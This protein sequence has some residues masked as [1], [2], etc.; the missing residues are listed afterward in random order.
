MDIAENALI[1]N[2]LGLISRA[3]YGCRL[4]T[5]ADVVAALEF[6]RTKGLPLRVLGAGSNVVPLPTVRGVVAVMSS[7]GIHIIEDASTE[8][9]LEIGAGENWH[10]LVMHCVDRGW[11]GIENLA[12]IPGSVGAAPVQN[13]GAYGVELCEV[14]D[15]VQIV[16]E[17][18]QLRWLSAKECEFGYR[19]S[20][21]Q[22]HSEL[23][24]VAVRL[25]LS[26]VA[27]PSLR[28]PDL[29]AYFADNSAV[30]A[31]Q[32][33]EAVI[34]IRS[35]KLPNPDEYPNV[36]SFFKNPVIDAATTD[37]F[38]NLGLSVYATDVGVKLSAAEL[39]DR[40]GWKEHPTEY[41]RCWPKQPLVLV[42]QNRANASHILSFA[43]D[44]RASVASTFGIQLELEPLVLS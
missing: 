41:V 8:L 2:T 9:L 31:R 24:I 3:E 28:Y 4:Q 16:D 43:N 30:T 10:Q 12:L 7:P 35:A 26:K 6:A 19:K 34:S 37:E 27:K 17:Q 29:A 20:L 1:P 40:C 33:A 42:C 11:S 36:G 18:Q 32:V 22:K 23:I 5:P 25:R 14:L 15:S 39:I 13:I 21:F 44:V 38:R